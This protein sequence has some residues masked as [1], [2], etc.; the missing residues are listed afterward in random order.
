MSGVPDLFKDANPFVDGAL[1]GLSAADIK[2]YKDWG[3]NLYGKTNFTDTNEIKK[4]PISLESQAIYIEKSVQSGL[5][6]EDLT[7]ND[8]AVLKRVRGTTWYSNLNLDEDEIKELELPAFMRKGLDKALERKV[9][10]L[11]HQAK[12]KKK[13][14]SKH[15]IKK[16]KRLQKKVKNE[17][18]KK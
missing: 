16:I 18:T 2:K 6:V 5:A 11:T 14:L 4:L 10:Q 17:K 1:K 15:T 12:R 7:P 9:Q 3:K 8:I 13:T